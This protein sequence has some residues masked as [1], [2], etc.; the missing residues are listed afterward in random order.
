MNNKDLQLLQEAAEEITN[1]KLQGLNK[2]I[3]GE[4]ESQ[5]AARTVEEYFRIIDNLSLVISNLDG[6]LST[7]EFQKFFKEWIESGKFETTPLYDKRGEEISIDD[8]A[9]IIPKMRDIVELFI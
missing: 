7:P 5:E 8:L 1:P 6:F 4:K 3:S 9:M 2:F